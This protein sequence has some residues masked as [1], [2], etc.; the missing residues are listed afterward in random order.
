MDVN[1][2]SASVGNNCRNWSFAHSFASVDGGAMRASTGMDGVI[3]ACVVDWRHA[4][5]KVL[6]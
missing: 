3:F 2:G 4:H 5:T 6:R 1:K